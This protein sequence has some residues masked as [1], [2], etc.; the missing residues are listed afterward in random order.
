[1]KYIRI[2][3][4]LLFPLA[5]HATDTLSVQQ[6]RSLAAQNHP[7]VTK[8][9]LAASMYD[10]Y[11]DNIDANYLPRISFS[12]QASWQTDVFKLPFDNPIFPIIDIPKDQY[13]ISADVSQKIWDGGYDKHHRAQREIERDIAMAQTAV[14]IYAVRETVT[15]L[16]FRV[17]L[18]QE[19]EQTL[20]LSLA[21]LDRRFKQTDAQVNEGV[22]LRSAA[23]QLR[24]Q[25][26]KTRQQ[27]SGIQSDRQALLNILALWIGREDTDFV[28]K[29]P[30]S[31]PPDLGMAPMAPIVR[32]EHQ[33][34]DLQKQ[35]LQVSADGLNLLLRPR[36]DAFAQGGFGQPNPL[37]PFETGFEPYFMIGVRALWTPINWGK[38]NR[39]RE[40]LSLQS[41]N[42]DAQRDAF[43]LRIEAALRKDHFEAQK[44]MQQSQL[45]KEIIVLQEDILKRSDA[46]VQNGVMTTT[47]YLTQVDLLTNAR[48][49]GIFH[50]L[51]YEHARQLLLAKTLAND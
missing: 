2:F 1:M 24:I 33:L 20:N 4:L 25:I 37:N 40:I 8:N 47:D 9:A 15:D 18:L 46:Q 27:A 12:G 22:A 44:M 6:C 14:D 42:I 30:K 32:P 13:K 50:Q 43:N 16:F 11:S 34:F 29:M 28:L 36:F 19:S 48:L 38:Q 39:E 3:F 51:Q 5:A 7:L 21:E 31:D 26:L 17:L 10:L 45:D 23:D 49:N 41:R 35:N